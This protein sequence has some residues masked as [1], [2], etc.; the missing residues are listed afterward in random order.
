MSSAIAIRGVSK[1]FGAVRAVADLDLETLGAESLAVGLQLSGRADL[2][3]DHH[4]P[5][6]VHEPG[7]DEGQERQVRR[8]RV[9]EACAAGTGRTQRS[10]RR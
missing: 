1:S 2:E 9:A 5:V 7:A 3:I 6:R 8:R 10:R 4:R